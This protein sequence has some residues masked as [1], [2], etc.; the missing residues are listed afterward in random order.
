MFNHSERFIP[1]VSRSRLEI[2][3]LH[4]IHVS[5]LMHSSVV[6]SASATFTSMVRITVA[7]ILYWLSSRIFAASGRVAG[8]HHFE[9]KIL[10][11]SQ[12]P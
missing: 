5:E 4:L 9:S 1:S 8:H 11:R 2:T 3:L 6:Q 7:P 10:S 12:M